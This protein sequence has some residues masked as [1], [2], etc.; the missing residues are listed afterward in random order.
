M[1]MLL[2]FAVVAFVLGIGVTAL[3]VRQYRQWLPRSAQM[4]FDGGSDSGAGSARGAGGV[5]TGTGETS[6]VP[7]PE[8]GAA[9][10]SIDSDTLNAR[11]VAIA[12][13]L[14]TLEARTVIVDQ[15]SRA[16]AGNSARAEA[17]LLAFAAR[18]AIDRGLGLGEIEGPLKR[19][20]RT[21]QARAVA[22]VLAASRAPVTL[23]DLRLSLDN[24]APELTSGVAVDGWVA[25]FQRELA[26][27][28]VIRH[29]G[30]ASPRATDRLA[31]VR[32]LLDAGKVDAALAEVGR[33]PGA[34]KAKAWI[35]AAG[36]YVQTQAALDAIETE[37]LVGQHPDMTGTPAQ[38]SG[39][40][41]TSTQTRA[42]AAL[43]P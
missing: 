17:L 26:G 30:T 25:S 20:F 33:L 37:A 4:M 42:T 18:R 31:R 36:R 43:T 19:R 23:E 38:P 40:G 12:A 22:T 10:R 16:A 2:W 13:Q 5:A 24:I 35:A 1:R 6:F 29:E 9:S 15:E 11:Q 8:A 32:H 21:T 39:P 14:A 3:F 7:P 27:L 28:I 41:Q 34:Q